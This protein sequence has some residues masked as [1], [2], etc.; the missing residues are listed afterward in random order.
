MCELREEIMNLGEKVESDETG[1]VC[2]SETGRVIAKFSHV[3]EAETFVEL[4]NAMPESQDWSGES[5]FWQE[6]N[7]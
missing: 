6:L 1:L 7:T 4:I 2:G 5:K 3:A